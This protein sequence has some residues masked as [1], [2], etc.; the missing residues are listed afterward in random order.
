[1]FQR[2]I[3]N[4]KR[5]AINCNGRFFTYSDILVHSQEVRRLVAP[6][7]TDLKG[8]KICF[9]C[10][11]SFEYVA[12]QW[13]VWAAG[14]CA[15]PLHPGHPASE[16]NYIVEDS[17]AS[18]VICHESL[19]DRLPPLPSSV[20]VVTLQNF[21]PSSNG[22]TSQQDFYSG[23]TIAHKVYEVSGNN[24]AMLVYTSGTT[25]KVIMHIEI[26][27]FSLFSLVFD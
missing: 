25:G 19:I 17:Q 3:D 7:T 6:R 27:S 14:G 13:G 12:S 22:N 21:H 10:P 20:R 26:A 1:L 4:R 9:L 2:A 23:D 8:Q 15:V 11:P 18:V 24:H 5:A 16:L